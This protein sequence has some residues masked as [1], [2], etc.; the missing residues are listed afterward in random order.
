MSCLN[1]LDWA[2]C[3]AQRVATGIWDSICQGFAD[4]AADMMRG[5]GAFFTGAT[6]INLAASGY[7]GTYRLLLAAAA[8]VAVIV[9]CLQVGLSVLR[10]DGSG[11]ARGVTGALQAG[12]AAAA[13]VALVQALLDAADQLTAGI[14][15]DPATY[16]DLGTRLYLVFRTDNNLAAPLLL[17]FGVLG[18]LVSLVLYLEMIARQAAI[19]V[20]VATSP[21]AMAGLLGGETR[22]WFRKTATWLGMLIALKPVVAAIFAVALDTTATATGINGVLSALMTLAIAAFAW[23]AL[24]RLLSFTSAGSGGGA[25]AVAGMAVGAGAARLGRR[26]SSSGGGDGPGDGEGASPDSGWGSAAGQVGATLGGRG[27]SG[28]A[29]GASSGGSASAGGGAAGVVGGVG[30][31]LAAAIR[32]SQAAG[33]LM[34]GMADHAGA[35]GQGY[36]GYPGTGQPPPARP[37]PSPRTATPPSSGTGGSTGADPPETAPSGA[38]AGGAS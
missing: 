33:G 37:R 32:G 18:V 26:S 23:P 13:V 36:Y 2:G 38:H 14:V 19:V 29:A 6:S 27:M 28:G 17:I 1:P 4:A 21:I 25:M 8:G 12:V 9:L 5:F 24:A 35:D 34:H 16:D 15:G 22:S 7:A 11:V 10:R 3:A 20:L 31:A 30:L